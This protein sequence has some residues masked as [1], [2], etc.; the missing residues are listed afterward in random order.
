MLFAML[1]LVDFTHAKHQDVERPEHWK[2][3]TC[4]GRF[5]DRFEPMPLLGE[6]TSVTWGVDDVKPRDVLNGIEEAQWSY[7]GGN[8]VQ[9]D[10]GKFHM[11]VC[12]WPENHPKGHMAWRGSEVVRAVSD[13]RLGPYKVAE[14][15]GAGHNPEVYRLPDGRYVCYVID[16]Y[17]LGKTIEGPWDYIT[18]SDLDDMGMANHDAPMPFVR[19]GRDD[20]WIYLSE[21]GKEL[22]M[23]SSVKRIRTNLSQIDKATAEDVP[24]YGIPDAGINR[25]NGWKAWIMNLYE[26]DSD[27]WLAVTHFEDQDNLSGNTKEDFRMGIAYSDDDGKTFKHL[28]F[29]LETEIP[30]AV[31][32]SG[33]CVSKMNIAGGGF[34]RDDTYFYL[35]YVDCSKPDRSDRHGAVARAEASTVIENARNGKNT[36]WH[37]CFDGKWEEPVMGGR[38]SDIGRVGDHANMMYNTY[39]DKWLSFGWDYSSGGQSKNIVMLKSSDP[40]D[41]SA[42]SEDDEVLYELPKGCVAHYFS[43]VPD[44]ADMTTCGKE[45]YLYY[46]YYFQ[47]KNPEYHTARLKVSFE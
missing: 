4:G 8:I 42:G 47:K 3:L 39:I 20:Y 10:D 45:F 16:A 21:G 19:L 27:E 22:P 2:D 18:Q 5:M 35:Y 12:R 11:F 23:H 24:I 7:W 14:V 15:I 36:V 13:N 31:I 34:R 32:K 33:V 43:V 44:Q 29:V 38:S 28:G 30:E 40:L 17:W 1:S 25:Y 41:F 9:N 37:K 6:R 46:R 26:I